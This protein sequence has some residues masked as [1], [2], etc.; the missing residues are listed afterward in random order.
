[1]ISP[2]DCAKI[3]QEMS[4]YM[5]IE[6][7][8]DMAASGML[9]LPWLVVSPEYGQVISVLDD[10]TGPTE[11]GSDYVFVEAET[12]QDALML[13]VMLFKQQGAKYLDHAESP[14]AGVKVESMVCPLH[15]MPQWRDDH[16]ECSG[17][18]G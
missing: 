8:K 4:R 1:M 9:L 5:D 17:C 7:I 10:G 2:E 16:F 12:E 13:G 6:I 18:E 3:G 11:Y 14:Y 15:G